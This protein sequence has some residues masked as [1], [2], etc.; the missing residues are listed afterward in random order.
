MTLFRTNNIIN[1]TILITL[2]ILGISNIANSKETSYDYLDVSIIR[3]DLKSITH[4]SHY[5]GYLLSASKSMNENVYLLGEYIDLE[6][7]GGYG[8]DFKSLGIGVH[9]PIAKNSDIIAKYVH[10]KYGQTFSSGLLNSSSKGI[11]NAIE[12]GIRHQFSNDLELNTE[13]S[14]YDFTGDSMFYKGISIGAIYKLNN[15]ISVKLEALRATGSPSN[16]ADWNGREVG[17]RYYF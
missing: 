3:Y 8:V 14:R 15:D 17:I 4:N 5:D 7:E 9:Y 12:L 2:L 6:R 10:N 16:S 13:L 1:K 11:Y